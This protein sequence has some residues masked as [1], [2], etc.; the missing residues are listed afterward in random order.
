MAV[1]VGTDL[2]MLDDQQ[3]TFTSDFY[4]CDDMNAD[5]EDIFGVTSVASMASPQAE[6]VEL[7]ALTE[8]MALLTA[9][10]QQLKNDSM[11]T[12]FFD[13]TPCS[14]VE[15]SAPTKSRSRSSSTSSSSSFS[16]VAPPSPASTTKRRKTSVV[17][18]EDIASGFVY[19]MSKE[20]LL[21][22]ITNDLPPRYLEGVIRIVNPSFD[23]TTA[24]DEDFEFDINSLAEH[25]LYQLMQYVRDALETSQKELIASAKR[26]ATSASRKPTSSAIKRTRATQAS[27]SSK[28]VPSTPSAQ[29]LPQAKR[30][31]NTS[32]KREGP[33]K[34][35]MKRAPKKRSVTQQQQ[36][37]AQEEVVI[38]SHASS[39][40]RKPSVQ[41]KQQ[42]QQQQLNSRKKQQQPV[43][44]LH[45]KE[46]VLVS[47]DLMREIFSSEEIIRVRKCLLEEDEEVDI[48]A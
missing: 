19:L 17:Q 38:T 36:Q 40:K 10:L 9:E 7:V 21:K 34:R 42:Q 27:H 22:T 28:S 32:N 43:K 24:T 31:S 25:V 1:A 44:P 18:D 26:Q 5:F 12:D 13:V 45:Q 30:T 16:S 35:L 15:A 41:T 4:D 47:G 48:L 11:I 8:E 39:S 3:H 46:T 37:Y 6:Q 33:R 23:P 14:L 29:P 2:F 20:E